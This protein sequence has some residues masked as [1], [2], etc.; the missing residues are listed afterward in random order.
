MT[1]ETIGRATELMNELLTII[2][3]ARQE[4]VNAREMSNAWYDKK[5][6]E[7]TGGLISEADWKCEVWDVIPDFDIADRL[8]EL[9]NEIANVPYRLRDVKRKGE[10]VAELVFNAKNYV[11]AGWQLYNVE[12]T[13]TQTNEGIVLNADVYAIDKRRAEQL[14]KERYTHASIG[15]VID[16]LRVERVKE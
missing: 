13:D 5:L 4:L 3:G 10:E 12:Y 11:P 14:I 2:D 16:V 7:K 6:A 9:R 15:N 8:R 1:H